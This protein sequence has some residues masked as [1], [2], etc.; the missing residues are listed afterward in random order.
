MDA[1]LSNL[2]GEL[3]DA[4][5][6]VEESK[7]ETLAPIA[8]EAAP[9]VKLTNLVLRDAVVQRASDIH[10]EPGEG[11]GV[12]RFRIDGV[13]RQHM[14]LQMS[15]LARV[16]SRVKVLSRLDIADRMRPQDG[17]ARLQIDGKLIDLRISTVPVRD[18]EK[19][20]I[21]VLRPDGSNT[22]DDAGIAPTELARLRQLLGFR[23]G[24]VLVTGPTGSGKTTTMYAALRELAAGDINIMTVEDPVEY[25]LPRISQIQADTKR[26]VT[27]A[28]ALRAILRQDPDVIFVGEIRDIETAEIAVQAAMT[29]HLVLA[30]LH[31]NDAMS[32]VARLNDLGL[33]RSALAATI[34]GSLAQRLTRRVCAE[35]AQT[36]D[37]KLVAVGCARC[38]NT[39]Y[40]G[41][42]P[43]HE[44]A[45]FT[46]EMSEMVA[47]GASASA[48]Q[49]AAV[50]AGM[51]TLRIT[52]MERVALGQTTTTE[53]ERVIGE[54]PHHQ[55]SAPAAPVE[56]R[57]SSATAAP[58]VTATTTTAAVAAATQAILVVDDDPIQR[59]LVRT[60]LER[61]GYRVSEATDGALAL[62]RLVGGEECSL[63]LTDLNMTEMDGDALIRQLRLNPRTAALPIVVLTGSAQDD[64]ESELI[65]IGADDYIKKPVDPPRL[66]ARVRAALRRVA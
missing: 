37:G 36:I 25:Q 10:I 11:Y 4:V 32:A 39:G 42:L 65:E 43:I 63:L 40:Y 2:D 34:R 35:C 59:L 17:R 3:A 33:E 56:P 53:I 30:T 51:R 31:T 50:R 21:R 58:R 64:R 57:A 15:T 41:R 48:L 44:V 6:V 61:S 9:I 13:M 7:P 52:A 27:F 5:S 19:V 45:V 12:V 22:L 18:A 24:I 55:P 38:A 47:E 54:A 66:L 29:G 62:A 26:G 14:Q 16:A 60:T 1:L 20:V 46:A 8:V 49:A 23:E 28:S